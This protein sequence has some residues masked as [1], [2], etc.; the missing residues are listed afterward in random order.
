MLT[1]NE[2]LSRQHLDELQL[3]GFGFCRLFD[4]NRSGVFKGTIEIIDINKLGDEMG[5]KTV[6]VE[7]FEGNN[8]VLVDEG[9][10]GTSKEAGAWMSR[11]EVL[12][13]GGF[14]FEYSATFGQAVA[15]GLTVVKAEQELI[16]RKARMLFETANLK[17]LDE[18]QM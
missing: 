10:R 18:S 6:A 14:A 12:V 5:D 15:K 4:K 1:P 11:R 7:A 9:H 17:K 8:L 16:K 13:R 3:S 2:G